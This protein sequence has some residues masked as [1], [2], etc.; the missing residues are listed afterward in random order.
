MSHKA[1]RLRAVPQFN[2]T[3]VNCNLFQILHVFLTTMRQGQAKMQ[4]SAHPMKYQPISISE[5]F[6]RYQAHA[7]LALVRGR[8]IN[9]GKNLKPTISS[10]QCSIG[11]L[12]TP[13]KKRLQPQVLGGSAFHYTRSTFGVWNREWSVLKTAIILHLIG[14]LRSATPSK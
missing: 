1:R 3:D 4:P 10:L 6:F 8:Y 11:S 9:L 14:V 13:K 5:H 2:D 7:T 12:D